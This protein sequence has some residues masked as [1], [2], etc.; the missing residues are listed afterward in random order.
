MLNRNFF[1]DIMR[2]RLLQIFRLHLIGESVHVRDLRRYEGRERSPRRKI[3]VLR[4][5][6][7]SSVLLSVPLRRKPACRAYNF[8]IYGINASCTSP[9][10]I[11]RGDGFSIDRLD[12]LAQARATKPLMPVWPRRTF[13]LFWKFARAII[14]Q[15]LALT[16]ISR[17]WS[18][19]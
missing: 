7:I 19:N 6:C 17:E 8:G 11:P 4:R 2:E 18:D 15:A 13:A 1:L 5:T 3:Y 16:I 10:A 12:Q 9:C 14:R